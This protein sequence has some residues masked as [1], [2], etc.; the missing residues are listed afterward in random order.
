MA[1]VGYDAGSNRVQIEIVV[2]AA[3]AANV[4]PQPKSLAER[5]THPKATPKSAASDKHGAAAKK[6]G[7]GTTARGRG[8]RAGRGAARNVRP[9]KKTAEEL[10]SEMADYFEGGANG[11]NGAPAQPAAA[12]PA[13]ANTD[14]QMNEDDIMVC[15][16]LTPA[17]NDCF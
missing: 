4:I 2:G 1:A 6:G 10:D 14:D 7:R 17:R 15:A 3:Q 13:P 9:S 12:A 11:N 5:A 16:L 8:A